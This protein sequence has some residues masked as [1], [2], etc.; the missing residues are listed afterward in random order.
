MTKRLAN[1]LLGAGFAGALLLQPGLASAQSLIDATDPD[2]L[3]NFFDDLGYD[4]ELGVD[5]YGD[6]MITGSASNSEFTLF[7]YGCQNNEDCTILQFSHAWDLVDDVSL[8]KVNEWN[9]DKLW[10]QAYVLEEGEVALSFVFNVE[11]GVTEDNL[12]STIDIWDQTLVEFE[13]FIGWTAA[14]PSGKPTK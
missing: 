6:P 14:A 1:L 9:V 8:E 13:E 4:V 10:G 2:A 3:L 7:F 11:D 12:E 5:D